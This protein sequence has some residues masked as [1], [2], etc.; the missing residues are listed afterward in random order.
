[1]ATGKIDKTE[2]VVAFAA[3]AIIGVAIALLFVRAQSKRVVGSNLDEDDYYYEG[4]D[5]FI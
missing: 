1:M 4:G 5:L 2:A 3:G